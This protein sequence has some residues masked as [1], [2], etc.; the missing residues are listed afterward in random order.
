[1]DVQVMAD[2]LSVMAM[3]ADLTITERVYGKQ[4]VLGGQ[5][6]KPVSPFGR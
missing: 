6:N 5:F 2:L 1:M 3:P 4:P